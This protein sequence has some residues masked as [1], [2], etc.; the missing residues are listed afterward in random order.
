MKNI[1]I[2]KDKD[3][4]KELIREEIELNG[5]ECD[6]NHID[7]YN[8]RDLSALFV[9]N[10]F[11]GDISKWN[12]SNVMNMREM[13]YKSRFNGDISAWNVSNVIDISFMFSDSQFDGDLSDWK[14]YKLER[15]GTAFFTSMAVEP[16]WAK[17]TYNEQEIKNK[18][19]DAYQLSKELK[20]ELSDDKKVNKKLKI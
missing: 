5:C 20:Q 12:T 8:I 10:K 1:I 2:A 17:F 13:F 3:H 14:P 16:Y 11:N 15:A 19:I 4:L 6:L 9:K 7:I 18:A